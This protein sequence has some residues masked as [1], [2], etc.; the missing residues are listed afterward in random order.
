MKVLWCSVE[1][2]GCRVKV[3]TVNLIHATPRTSTSV[4]V[5][6]FGNF[7]SHKVF[8]KLFCKNQFPHSLCK[9]QFPHKSVNLFFILVI[10]KDT[11]TVLWGIGLLQ[12]DFKKTSCEITL[13]GNFCALL[14]SP[15]PVRPS[16]IGMQGSLLSW[17]GL[18]FVS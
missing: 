2:S 16:R 7:I 6:Q 5:A 11:L 14:H 13:L 18:L 17:L 15:F 12:N 9:S 10:V 3:S 1:G 8:I 4:G